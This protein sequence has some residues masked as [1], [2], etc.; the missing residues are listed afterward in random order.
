MK[1][2]Q[3]MVHV[4]V[5]VFPFEFKVHVTNKYGKYTLAQRLVHHNSTL[6]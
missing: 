2:T 4:H 3:I 1:N 5:Y 6:E